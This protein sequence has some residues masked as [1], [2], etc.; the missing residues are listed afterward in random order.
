MTLATIRT[1]GLSTIQDG[2]RRGFTEVGVPVSGAFHRVR[3]LVATA[4]ISGSPDDR[5]PSIELLGGDLT[6]DV[7]TTMVM[8]VVGPAALTIDGR[9]QAGG[10]AV[11]VQAGAT[12]VVAHAGPG[13]AYVVVDGWTP[14]LT[15]GSAATDT[16]SGIG[17]G[18]LQPGAV[19][20]GSPTAAGGRRVGVFHRVLVEPTGPLGVAPTGHPGLR[21]FVSATW[22]VTSIA[23]SGARLAGG[24]IPAAGSVPSMPTIP[25]A[26]QVTPS[27]EVLV[28]GPD[29]GLTGGYPVVAVVTTAELDRLS[30]L[31]TGEAVTFRT[32]E[33]DEAVAARRAQLATVRRAVAHPDDLP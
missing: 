10:T 21:T 15:L 23:R 4:L 2:G 20:A 11:S 29:G 19:L 3:Y 9:R 7:E 13:P 8:A 6:I 31:R 12:V 32:V 25:G 16:F 33:I 30:L 14:R 5:R 28:L 22:S 18:A 27:G 24:P 1:P 17:G 26:I